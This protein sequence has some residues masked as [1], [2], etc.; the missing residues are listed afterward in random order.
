MAAEV[1][2]AS[3]GTT[4]RVLVVWC[5]DW[6]VIAAA[7]EAGLP[8]GTPIAVVARG[9]V[10]ACSAAARV[11]GV[12]RGMRQRD[13]SA[14]CPELVVVEESAERDL[15]CFDQVLAAVE[16]V[17]STACPIRPGLCATGVPSRFY[18]GEQEATAV[19]AERL[20]DEGVW[21]CRFGV[22][23]GIFAGEQAARRAAPQESLVVPPGATARFLADLPI[24][25][26]EDADMVSLLRRLGIR[27]LGDFAALAVRDVLTR[28]GRSGEWWHRLARG[29]DVRVVSGRRAPMDASAAVAFEPALETIEPI[30]FSAR[31]T[32]ERCVADLAHHG[33]VCTSV[34]VEVSG[35]FGWTGVR[36]WAHS[37]WFGA[38]DLVDRLYWQLQAHPA[39]EPVVGVRFVPETVESL[40][41]QGEGLWGSAPDERLERGIARLQGMLGPE[42]VVAP[43]V[44]GGRSAA[45]RQ[46]GSPW[47]ERG[48]TPRPAGL[49]WPGSIPPPAPA[50]VFTDPQPARVTAHDGSPVRIT[51]RGILTADPVHVVPQP[52]IGPMPIVG[53]AGP[54]P[55][56]ELWWDPTDARR[57]ARFQLV[58][59]DGSAWL[60]VVEDG[61]WWS[62]AR[63][64]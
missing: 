43:G 16:D 4:H 38:A 21:D 56:D 30:V 33:L 50:R 44:Q 11:E 24:G 46:A 7:V 55:I 52:G 54:W 40:A 25:V 34:T 37:R 3:A 29:L 2:E 64:D 17:T 19:L 20:V 36:T 45:R 8:A 63:Y 35:D 1:L 60:M 5:P 58:G 42:A 27:T 49:P 6:P 41:D 10:L 62:E 53:W 14:H 51:D 12:R 9:A 26:V 47:G 48:A 59:G 61:Q 15:R 13:A 31:R 39:P 32:A 57:V 18:G 28:F 22:A 23:D